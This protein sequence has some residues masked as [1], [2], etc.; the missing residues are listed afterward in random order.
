MEETSRECS[1]KANAV[2]SFDYS[3][4]PFVSLSSWAFS[5]PAEC[6]CWRAWREH[7][8]SSPTGAAEEEIPTLA[9]HTSGHHPEVKNKEKHLS[10]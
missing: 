7:A 2:S 10:P 3:I 9:P 6:R 4:T 1:G 5:K 8:Q